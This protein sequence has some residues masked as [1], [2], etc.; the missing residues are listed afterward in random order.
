MNILGRTEAGNRLVEMTDYEWNTLE[1]IGERWFST[2]E[3]YDDT[4]ELRLTSV[5]EA[6]QQLVYFRNAV[7]VVLRTLRGELWP[8]EK[9]S[10]DAQAP[11]CT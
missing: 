5:L 9:E 4:P 8:L 1:Q 3:P 2:D 6:V 7:E 10:H 11:V